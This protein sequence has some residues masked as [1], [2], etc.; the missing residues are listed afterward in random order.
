MALI[1]CTECGKMISS[2]ALKCPDCGC[3]VVVEKPKMV[4]PECGYEVP[5][6]SESCE[7]CGCP[8]EMFEN[9]GSIL[10]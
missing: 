7:N 10:S 2:R 5:E 3:P 8:V 9:I 1:K 6:S 4:C